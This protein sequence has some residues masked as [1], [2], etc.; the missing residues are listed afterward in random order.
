[1]IEPIVSLPMAKPQS[2]AAT[3]DADPALEPL[4]PS[5]GFQGLRVTPRSQTS[6]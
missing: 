1:M 5:R 4:E 2:P 6:P 3:A